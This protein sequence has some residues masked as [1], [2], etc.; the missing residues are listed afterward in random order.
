M[1]PKMPNAL[2]RS[3]GSVNVVVSSDRIAGASSAANAPC[4]ARAPISMPTSTDGAADGR[5]D[6]EADQADEEDPLAADD[7]GD[8]AADQQQRAEG[9]RVGGDDPLAG[10][11]GEREVGLRGRQRDV[12]DRRVE[13]DHQLGDA[14]DGEDP[15]ALGVAGARRIEVA[16]VGDFWRVVVMCTPETYRRSVLRFIGNS[17]PDPESAAPV[18]RDVHHRTPG[19][20]Q[21]DA[22]T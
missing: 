12:H 13:H 11:V 8:P 3:F 2:A 17:T 22:S 4:T 16:R 1:A 20:Q 10:V 5:G 6:R 21:P 18:C 7:V 14:E 9:Q 15:P 19:S